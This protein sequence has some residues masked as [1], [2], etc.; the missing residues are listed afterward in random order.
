MLGTLFRAAFRNVM[1]NT[2][3]SAITAL[4]VLIGTGAIVIGRGCLNGIYDIVIGGVTLA[5]TG[6]VQVHK[7]GYLDTTEALPLNLTVQFDDDLE[8]LIR[9]DERVAE[10]S[11][12]IHFSGLVTDV[13]QENTTVFYGF[14]MDPDHEFSITPRNLE[15]VVDGQA[16]S[17]DDPTGIVLGEELAR[18]LGLKVGD[19]VTLLVNTKHGS[20]NGKDVT[21][22]GIAAFKLPGLVNKAVHL[23]LSTAQ[24][25]LYLDGE[26]T[27]VAVKL[28]EA[29]IPE[30]TRYTQD[31]SK[32]L[33]GKHK[34]YSANSWMEVSEFYLESL[35]MIDQVFAVLIVI[36]FVVMVAGIINTMLMSVLERVS[37]IGTMM[38]LGVK[39]KRILGLF[40]IE[41][42]IL[43]LMG[44]LLGT[45][46]GLLIVGY[47][48][49]YGLLLPLPGGH[50]HPVHPHVDPVYTIGIIVSALIVS[51][52][53]ALYPA[54][55]ASLLTPVDALRS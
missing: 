55:R 34:E 49:Y 48:D 19:E 12:R 5:V 26:V 52:A 35:S 17:N 47:Y 10:V 37:E 20:L 1:R 11:G 46:V 32:T 45:G 15:N 44:A 28:H 39:R 53:S 23:P 29:S 51:T 30:V 27:E 21:V 25:L 40:L 2:R 43:G 13:N 42:G 3:R 18:N 33:E 36:F 22:R 8:G 6:D 38:A 50:E 54:W 7:K 31:L 24:K 14:A 4:A 9:D 41:A 16:L